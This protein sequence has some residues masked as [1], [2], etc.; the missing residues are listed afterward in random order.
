MK[1]AS[2]SAKEI[3][4]R[5]API[6]EQRFMD[7]SAYSKSLQQFCALLPENADILEIACGPGNVTRF[8]IDQRPDLRILATDIAPN[9]LDLAKKNVPAAE[10]MELDCRKI[11]TLDRK[12]DA[13]VAAFCLPYLTLQ[14]AQCF[15]QD[16]GALLNENGMLYV[17][18][19]EGEHD[20]CGLTLPSTGEGPGTYMSFYTEHYLQN[21]MEEAGFTLVLCDRVQQ[22]SDS[23]IDLLLIAKL[24]E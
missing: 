1:Q 10:I 17:S 8:I 21:T 14:E 19:M 9:M 18:T 23:D 12:F 2:V 5:Y 22:S 16:C 20:R 15:V 7:V 6:Y 13:I 11:S 3:F 4:D 24:A